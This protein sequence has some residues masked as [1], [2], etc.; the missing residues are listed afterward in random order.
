[1]LKLVHSYVTSIHRLQKHICLYTHMLNCMVIV[2]EW[3]V[4]FQDANVLVVGSH[5]CWS[6]VCHSLAVVLEAEAQE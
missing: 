4:S 5:S 2:S 3:G 6:A 1:M